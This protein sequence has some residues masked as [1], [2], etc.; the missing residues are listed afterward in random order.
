MKIVSAFALAATLTVALF[1][2]SAMADGDADKGEKV[3]KKCKSCHTVDSGGKHKSGPNLFGVYGREVA[4]TDFSKYKAL[5][6]DDGV[7]DEDNLDK[8]LENPKKYNGK[9]TSM[10][11]KL[12]KEDDREDVIA[13]LKTLK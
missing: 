7:W 5:S 9:K 1:S 8:W 3:F 12:K 10:S 2:G 11:L 6:A 4:G 13:Y